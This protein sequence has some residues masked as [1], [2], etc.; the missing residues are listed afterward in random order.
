M[1][2]TRVRPLRRAIARASRARAATKPLIPTQAVGLS[3]D[4][5]TLFYFNEES[6]T[7]EA[8]WRA[9]NSVTSALYDMR[10]LGA[11][12]GAAANSACNRLYSETN[13]DIVVE[14]D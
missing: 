12:R 7:E 6:G 4:G 10:S 1:A 2:D 3:T 13:G 14:K 8:R 5:R 9:T 11:R